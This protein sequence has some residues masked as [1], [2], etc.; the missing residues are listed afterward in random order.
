MVR[1]L[2]MNSCLFGGILSQC[3][4]EKSPKSDFSDRELFHTFEQ[5]LYDVVI[6]PR[7]SYEAPSAYKLPAPENCE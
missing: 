7:F 5:H 4:S 3:I 2:K 1:G 6:Q